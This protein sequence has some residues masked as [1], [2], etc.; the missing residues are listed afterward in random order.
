MPGD[1]RAALIIDPVAMSEACGWRRTN[2]CKNYC[3][4]EQ[5]NDAQGV[6][7]GYQ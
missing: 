1:G 2:R 4:A 5:G 7:R 3:A 6:K